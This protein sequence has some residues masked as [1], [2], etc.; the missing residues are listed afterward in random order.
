MRIPALVLALFLAV[1]AAVVPP[2]TAAPATLDTDDL[3]PYLP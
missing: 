3:P 2:V 1:L